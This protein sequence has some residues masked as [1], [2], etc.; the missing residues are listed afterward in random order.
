MT[1]LATAE[2]KPVNTE[3]EVD[4]DDDM[5]DEY[6]DKITLA[7]GVTAKDKRLKESIPSTSA[8]EDNLKKIRKAAE[9]SDVEMGKKKLRLRI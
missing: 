7:A 8:H 6:C 4:V 2:V 1:E 3:N 9:K 5:M